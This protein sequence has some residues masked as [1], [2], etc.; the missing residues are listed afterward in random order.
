MEVI[1]NGIDV[2]THQGAIEWN[3]VETDFAIIRAG[4]SWYEGGMD[5]DKRFYENVSG[6]ETNSIPFGVY[7]YAY[8][9]TPESAKISARKLYDLIKG[10]KLQYPVIYDFEDQ[11]YL[12]NSKN[13]NTAI[14]KAFL[15]ELESF[16][17]YAMLYTYTNFADNYLN[18]D[19]L[20]NYDFWVADYRGSVG[21]T[22][23]YGI[24]QYSSKGEVAGINTPVDLNISYKDYPSI[25]KN[26]GLNGFNINDSDLTQEDTES[27][28]KQLESEIEKR[29]CAE[30]ELSNLESIFSELKSKLKEF[31]DEY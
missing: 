11:Q 18:M 3:R 31:I 27:L 22:G 23:N 30:T 4:W 17:Y 2:S 10:Y 19:E 8:D 16:G 13:S 24:W 21:Y 6:A 7:L 29:K 26:A 9:K 28:I 25:I 5:I 15:S 1:K 20:A 14:C 12:S